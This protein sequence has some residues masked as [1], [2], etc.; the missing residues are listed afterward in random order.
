M[1]PELSI[2]KVDKRKYRAIAQENWGL[3]KEQMKGMHVHHRI[4]VSDE[5][6]NDPSNLYVCSPS[7]HRWGWHNGEEFIEWANEGSKNQPREA[8]AKGGKKAAELGVGIHGR[9]PEQMA[10]DRRKGGEKVLELGVGIYGK[11]AEQVIE[12]ASRGG[13][14]AAELGVGVHA[15]GMAS[16]GGKRAAELGVGFHGRSPEQMTEDGKKGGNK[17][18]EI[19]VGIH[20][21]SP[22]QMTEDG[23]K[24]GNK[25]AELGVGIHAPGMASKGAKAAHAQKWQSTDPNHPAHISNSGGLSRWQKARG[26]DTSMRVKLTENE[27]ET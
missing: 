7:M 27:G 18:A 23:K 24:G 3:T 14:K 12:D 19:G 5:G 25:A 13:K 17:A 6:T 11:S 20:G 21:R 15:P 26:I 2:V 4:P 22:E 16:K 8:K 1:P 10:E 9:S